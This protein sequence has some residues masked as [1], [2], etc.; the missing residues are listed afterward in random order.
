MSWPA[1]P[2]LPDGLLFSGLKV[3]DAASWLAG[4]ASA[5]IL[6][7]YGADVIKVE[8]PGAG[9]GYRA[10][11][12]AP[13]YPA[14]DFDYMWAADNRN[15]RGI[16]LNLAEPEAK[17]VLLELVRECDVYVTNQP[18]AQRRR[19]GLTYE[20]L[21]PENPRLIYASL[22]AY[23]ETGDDAD[24]E[25]FDAHAYWGR[26]GLMHE[27]H[28]YGAAPSWSAPGQGDHPTAVAMYAAIV[29][30]LLQRERTGRGML[31][32]T[33]LLA[34]GLWSNLCWAQGAFAGADFA[35]HYAPP[36]AALARAL[37]EAA[38]GRTLQIAALRT[39]E[40]IVRLLDALELGDL[41]LEER[42]ATPE[43]RAAN[44]AALAVA[45]GDTFRTRPALEWRSFLRTRGLLVNTVTRTE[46]LPLDPQ[47]RT[48]GAVVPLTDPGVGMPLVINHPVNVEGRSASDRRPR[49]GR[50]EHTRAI[51]AA[52]GRS[53]RHHRGLRGAWGGLDEGGSRSD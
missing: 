42:F 10:L 3:V 50:G 11:Y 23:G 9:D 43:G 40:Q 15:K 49:L 38:D 46:D 30:G 13:R 37:F 14:A 20:E 29:T 7:D 39:D 1:N 26:S 32:H 31:V 27:V 53:P 28:A 12:R 45:L 25:G 47:L 5:T 41:L 34:N 21:A 48:I 35:P 24:D 52:L 8:A 18:L 36:G 51:P 19:F 16:V 4:P 22:T 6:A 2:D 44:A 33:S 17:A